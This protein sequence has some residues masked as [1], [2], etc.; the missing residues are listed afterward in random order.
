MAR[1]CRASQ[2]RLDMRQPRAP[3]A[4]GVR[5][6]VRAAAVEGQRAPAA[7]KSRNAAVAILQVEQP[8]ARRPARRR[9]SSGDRRRRGEAARAARP[10]YRRHRARRR[11]DPSRPSRRARRACRDA[12]RDTAG[13]AAIRAGRPLLGRER[14]AADAARALIARVVTHVARLVSIGQLPSGGTLARRNAAPLRATGC[15]ALAHRR[16]GHRDEARQ[17]RRFEKPAV[18]RLDGLQHAQGARPRHAADDPRT[19]GLRAGRK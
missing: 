9:A 14:G 10:V 15:L 3:G 6:Q 18:L 12:R 1:R 16:R 4:Q 13:R 2:R 7:A 19:S 5:G 8:S 11:A 17:R